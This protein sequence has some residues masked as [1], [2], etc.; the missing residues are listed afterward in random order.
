M[1]KICFL[2]FCLI[3]LCIPMESY[4]ASTTSSVEAL[5][6]GTTFSSF[7]TA[8][9]ILLS[10]VW[11]L[12]MLAYDSIHKSK[13]VF[14]DI[15]ENRKKRNEMSL[16]EVLTQK[17]RWDFNVR[18]SLL[19]SFVNEDGLFLHRSELEF[20]YN[21]LRTL[22]EMLPT[23]EDLVQR[24]NSLV[25]AAR[26]GFS[27]VYVLWYSKIGKII[28]VCGGLLA[29]ASAIWFPSFLG[30]P[31]TLLALYALLGYTPVVVACNPGIIDSWVVGLVFGGSFATL[32]PLG[33]IGSYRETI[34][35]ERYTDRVV[36]REIDFS[37]T[38][39]ACFLLVL[40]LAVLFV[41]YVIRMEVMFIRNYMIFR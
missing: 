14:A 11:A 8:V 21:E 28:L 15:E 24:M 3:G 32:V 33:E 20:A 13:L 18:L 10:I 25:E 17:E 2:L 16:S 36:H 6:E 34:W 31:L 12:L 37:P 19:E 22:N 23:D 7:L 38:L 26:A 30:V 1:K 40:L 29:L 39:M 9:I 35:K 27:R 4:A 5:W 41:L